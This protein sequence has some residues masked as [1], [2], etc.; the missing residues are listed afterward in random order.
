MQSTNR[1]AQK[2]RR[3]ETSASELNGQPLKLDHRPYTCTSTRRTMSGRDV[4]MICIFTL[5]EGKYLE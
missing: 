4:T 3:Q 2:P 5:I 1:E